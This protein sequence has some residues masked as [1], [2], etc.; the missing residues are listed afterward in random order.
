MYVYVVKSLA[1]HGRHTHWRIYVN[2][3]VYVNS[4][5][6]LQPQRHATQ[7]LN[8]ITNQTRFQ[9]IN[10]KPQKSCNKLEN[11]VCTH[12][13]ALSLLSCKKF[14]IQILHTFRAY[15]SESTMR[16]FKRAGRGRSNNSIPVISPFRHSASNAGTM[17]GQV[18][19]QLT[20]PN[21]EE[22]FFF[23]TGT[24]QLD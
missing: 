1:W 12:T 16:E 15:A 7:L 17:W 22:I 18:L 23:N 21:V 11:F 20:L 4:L 6:L 2:M 19:L 3:Y 14:I 8:Q 5:V 9:N 24:I 10:A 13:Q